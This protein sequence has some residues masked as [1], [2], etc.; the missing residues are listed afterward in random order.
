[1]GF[2]D[3]NGIAYQV[4]YTKSDKRIREKNQVRVSHE[5]HP[6][7]AADVLETSAEKKIGIDA[8]RVLIG[9]K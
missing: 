4:I 1:M 3:A 8:I 7:M 2:C 9:I 6:A 5:N